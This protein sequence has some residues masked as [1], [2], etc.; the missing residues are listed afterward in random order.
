[1]KIALATTWNQQCGISEY[2]RSLVDALTRLGHEVTIL[3]S[4]VF[5]LLKED[6]PF[7][8]RLGM[9]TS[10]D[11]LHIQYSSYIF[12]REYINSILT[13]A[14]NN[15]T[16]CF[17]T[18]HDQFLPGF[19]YE[20]LD[21]IIAHRNDIF[22]HLPEDIP[23]YVMPSGVLTSPVRITSFGLGRNKNGEIQKVCDKLGFDFLVSDFRNWISQEEL[24]EFI[25]RG[26]ATVLWY[27]DN[28]AAGSSSCARIAIG[29][30]RPLFV[31]E[32]EWFKELH[33]VEDVLFFKHEEDLE[34]KLE[35]YFDNAFIKSNNWD[36]IAL[37]HVSIYKGDR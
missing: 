2:S 10:C 21:G 28:K 16:K 6:E 12:T 20:K 35:G 25:K 30:R 17:A 8:T 31:S 13:I 5:P 37:K 22:Q 14:S 3:G 19:D 34:A 36:T 29:A 18:F 4:N 9:P 24:L 1:M 27:P 26:D 15:G 32:C 33:G 11:I 7:V 23:K